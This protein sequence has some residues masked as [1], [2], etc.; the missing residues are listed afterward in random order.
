MVFSPADSVLRSA[1]VA[2]GLVTTQQLDYC[3]RVGRHRQSQ[4]GSDPETPVPDELLAQ[5]LVEQE[6][7]TSYQ[8]NQLSQGKTKL[9]LGPYVVTDWIGQGGMGQV[10]KAVHRVMGRECAVK[11]LR[12]ATSDSLKSFAHEIRVQAKLD[13][14][15]LV[16]AFDAGQDG[17][18][19][20]LVTEYVPGRDLRALVKAKGP[21]SMQQAAQIVMQAALGLKYAHDEGMVHRDVKPANILVTPDGQAKV[22][23]VGLAGFA[24]DLINDPRAGKIVG[25]TD[26]LSPEQIRTPLDIKPASDIYSLGCTLYY[27]VCGKVPFPGGDTESKLRRHLYEFPLHPRQFVPDISEDFAD[28]IVDMMEKDANKRIASA[29]EV[30][31][32]L[33]PWAC[34]VSQIEATPLVASPWAPAPPPQ[35]MQEPVFGDDPVGEPGLAGPGAAPVVVGRDATRPGSD[36]VATSDNVGQAA[37]RDVQSQVS[38]L[39]DAGPQRGESQGAAQQ[40]AHRQYAASEG[41]A[42]SFLSESADG[43]STSQAPPIPS[44]TDVVAAVGDSSATAV[45]ELGK[46]TSAGARDRLSTSMVVALTIAIVVPPTLLIGAIIGYLTRG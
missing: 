10:Y 19:H 28:I 33:E 18:V 14:P 3:L 17:R 35:H 21:L 40:G 4:Q 24:S 41:P 44:S 23:D 6:H 32:R 13:C 29:G 45:R 37:G 22:S 1:V 9:N 26:Y 46:T 7:L 39:Q 36:P 31:S 38:G 43:K 15:Y 20:Y 2:S 27:A 25:T 42:G 5:I 16:R 30:A 34:E 12:T 11:V 8:A